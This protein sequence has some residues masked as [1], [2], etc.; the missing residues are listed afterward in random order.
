MRLISTLEKRST[1]LF[2]ALKR[3][4][5]GT[6]STRREP[7][8]KRGEQFFS[9]DTRLLFRATLREAQCKSCET[10]GRSSPRREVLSS[11]RDTRSSSSQTLPVRYDP[12]KSPASVPSED[13]LREELLSDRHPRL[14]RLRTSALSYVPEP[15]SSIF[16]SSPGSWCA[17]PSRTPWLPSPSPLR[18]EV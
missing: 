13:P 7:S 12:R 15:A 5:P 11:P 17:G 4:T 1:V 6:A 2:C 3:E 8:E 18:G 14:F 9:R 16:G 10:L